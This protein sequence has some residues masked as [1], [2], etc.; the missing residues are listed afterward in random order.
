MDLRQRLPRKDPAENSKQGGR[1]HP[2]GQE[3]PAGSRTPGPADGGPQ[4]MEATAGIQLATRGPKSSSG[5]HLWGWGR[6][7]Q[8]RLRGVGWAPGPY[9]PSP[10]AHLWSV[11]AADTRAALD[12]GSEQ[13]GRT[14]GRARGSWCGQ[15]GP[16]GAGGE[17]KGG[18]G[19][20]AQGEG[21]GQNPCRDQGWSRSPQG[22]HLVQPGQH[23]V[24]AASCLCPPGLATCLPH[25]CP[26]CPQPQGHRVRCSSV[27]ERL[28]ESGNE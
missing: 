23:P 6:Q 7:Q 9:A 25:W 21:G 11:G 3:T 14:Q 26:V 20:M 18:E 24:P 2:R 10:R 8:P 13:G 19:M 5:V 27:G 15:A 1:G 16:R 22:T 28:S 12:E 4:G 17:Q